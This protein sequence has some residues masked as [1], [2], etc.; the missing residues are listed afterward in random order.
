MNQRYTLHH[1]AAIE[2]QF[3]QSTYTVSESVGSLSICVQLVAGYLSQQVNVTI[4]SQ[5]GTATGKPTQCIL[6]PV[7]LTASTVTPAGQYAISYYGI[8]SALKFVSK[9]FLV[10]WDIA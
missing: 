4:Q 10:F 9:T 8:I 2:F 6:T 7:C 3:N 5:D 1:A